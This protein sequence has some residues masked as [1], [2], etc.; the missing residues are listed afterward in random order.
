MALY[1]R[2]L[3]LT[4][5]LML[6]GH[7]PVPAQEGLEV[8]P[9][10]EG[11]PAGAPEQPAPRQPAVSVQ[12]PA[13]EMPPAGQPVTPPPVPQTESGAPA[14]TAP[15]LAAEPEPL[16]FNTVALQGVN[17][18]TA[19]ISTIDAPI[20]EVVRF[21]NLE[22]IARACWQSPPENQPENATLLEIWELK[23]GEGPIRIFLGWM[24]SSSPALSSLEHAVYDV[25]VLSC[26][27][28]ESKE[29]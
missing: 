16:P 29:E 3:I 25:T 15:A 1:F 17:K 13:G 20:G 2:I 14:E 6:A 11:I 4:A 10:E 28:R 12:S 26:E 8:P 22:I 21:G 24:F 9:D 19:R 5:A 18:V 7:S 27:R 23:P